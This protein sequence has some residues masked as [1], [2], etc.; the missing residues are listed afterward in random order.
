MRSRFLL[1]VAVLLSAEMYF[2]KV[3]HADATPTTLQDYLN[4]VH[5][6]N[7]EQVGSQIGIEAA[8]LKAFESELIFTPKLFAETRIGSDGKPFNPPLLTYDRIDMQSYSAGLT[9]QFDFGL[10]TKLYYSLTHTSYI[11]SPQLTGQP[12]AY[13]DANPTPE[14]SMPLWGNGFGRTS[15]AQKSVTIKS[16]EAEEFGFRA[17]AAGNDVEAENTYW[18]LVV[19]REVLRVQKNALTQAQAIL[20]Y[21]KKNEDRNFKRSFASTVGMHPLG[22]SWAA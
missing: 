17:R 1:Y 22:T 8:K 14:V 21:V 13:Y 20:S 2:G 5:G 12:A 19:A 10:Q 6:K 16:N 18:S 3:A 9:E 11:N 4:Q 15:R 7:Q